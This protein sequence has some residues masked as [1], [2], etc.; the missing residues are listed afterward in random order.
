MDLTDNLHVCVSDEKTEA[1]EEDL[2]RLYCVLL[3]SSDMEQ[4]DDTLTYSKLH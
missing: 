2:C 3:F 4:L 1:R